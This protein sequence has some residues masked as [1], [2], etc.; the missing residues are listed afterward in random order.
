MSGA[1]G[2]AVS[3]LWLRADAPSLGDVGA[4]LEREGYVAHVAP[5]SAPDAHAASLGV[6]AV[7]LDG[8]EEAGWRFL[9][10]VLSS[11]P[12]LPIVVI[13]DGLPPEARIGLLDLGVAAHVPAPV[14]DAVLAARLRWARARR[15][16]RTARSG[17]VLEVDDAQRRVWLNGEA[18]DLPRREFD[19][20]TM[21]MMNAGRVVPRERLMQ[22]VWGPSYKPGSRSLDVRV[23]RLRKLLGDGERE[24]A[25]AIETV[26]GVGY[27]LLV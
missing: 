15:E 17:P 25:P 7:L 12:D 23:S 10:S 14:D 11:R 24:A 1:A 27:R 2:D 3:L 26:P 21:L 20:L 18:L 5:Q 13:A 19:V 6:D 8:L 16:R 9:R 22:S 4:M